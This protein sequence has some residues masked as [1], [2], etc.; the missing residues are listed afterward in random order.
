MRLSTEKTKTKE[1]LTQAA[2]P[3]QN[4]VGKKKRL[5]MG[6]SPV[7]KLLD[8]KTK[9]WAT[10]NYSNCAATE[11]AED[12]KGLQEVAPQRHIMKVGLQRRD[13]SL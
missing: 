3:I 9:K 5:E 11:Q 1:G 7:Q 8:S 13:L 10:V 4:K 12:Y 2:Q 6:Q